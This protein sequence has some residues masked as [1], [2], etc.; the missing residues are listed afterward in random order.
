MTRSGIEKANEAQ[1]M[2]VFRWQRASHTRPGGGGAKSPEIFWKWGW[3]SYRGSI[4]GAHLLFGSRFVSSS[5]EWSDSEYTASSS[6]P[7]AAG[8]SEITYFPLQ[9]E[10]LWLFANVIVLEFNRRR[11]MGCLRKRKWRRK[12]KRKESSRKKEGVCVWI[13]EGLL[14]K[15]LGH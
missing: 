9:W 8:G 5:S 2:S 11:C 12:G 10:A 15:Y 3:T 1:E 4:S 6:T 7:R 13:I 14:L